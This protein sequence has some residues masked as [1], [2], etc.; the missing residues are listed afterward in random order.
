MVFAKLTKLSTQA[1]S[2]I[3][4]RCLPPICGKSC[5]LQ[6]GT[7]WLGNLLSL[8]QVMV[9]FVAT[10]ASSTRLQWVTTSQAST[11]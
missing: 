7:C 3:L 6:L 8:A 10:S 9:N 4:L 2:N 11:N 5:L 1:L